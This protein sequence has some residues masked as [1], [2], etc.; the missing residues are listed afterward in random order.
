MCPRRRAE[1][2]VPGL[3]SL[4]APNTLTEL[5]VS[6]N[7]QELVGLVSDDQ[8]ISGHVIGQLK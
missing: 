5:Q 2:S 6:G 8:P 4:H 1:V 3:W 7:D